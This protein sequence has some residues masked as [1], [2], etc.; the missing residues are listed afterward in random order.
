MGPSPWG[1][2]QVKFLLFAIDYFTKSVEAEALA[3]IMEA[4]V[5]SFVWKNIVCRLKIP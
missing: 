2:K 4:K 1:K 5:Q 3:I